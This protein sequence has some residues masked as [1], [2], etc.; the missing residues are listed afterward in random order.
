MQIS[1]SIY[2]SKGDVHQ[3]YFILDEKPR[4]FFFIR[5]SALTNHHLSM[6]NKE[7]SNGGSH[8]RVT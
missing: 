5:E 2:P 7:T 1:E 3:V 6:P 4:S 8:V